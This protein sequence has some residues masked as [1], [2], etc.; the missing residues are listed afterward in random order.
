MP[1][2]VVEAIR[3]YGATPAIP[4]SQD[5]EVGVGVVTA[6][7]VLGVVDTVVPAGGSN[8]P[9]P[10]AGT[11]WSII[12]QYALRVTQ[13]A[14]PVTMLS[15]VRFFVS[16][17]NYNALGGAYDGAALETADGTAAPADL[18]AFIP[19]GGTQGQV[20]PDYV[21]ATRTLGPQGYVGNSINAVYGFTPANLFTNLG[22]G[23]LDLTGLGRS[24]GTT[25]TFGQS[26]NDVSRLFLVQWAVGSGAL[27]GAKPKVAI[28]VRYDETV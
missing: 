23:L 16:Q 4:P 28:T 25:A 1:D 24:D 12:G 26:V 14:S 22:A 11:N 17:A 13:V 18:D 15:N 20:D 8:I 2:A 7:D 5:P 27:R 6:G 19:Q 21:Q 10:P 3:I 9:I